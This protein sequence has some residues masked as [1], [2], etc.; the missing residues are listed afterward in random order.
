MKRII[1]GDS[2]TPLIGTIDMILKHWGYR[3]YTS[4]RPEQ[5][6]AALEEVSPDLLIVGADLLTDPESELHR[7]VTRTVGGGDCPLLLLEAPGAAEPAGIAQGSL[8][9]P[10][11]AFALFAYIQELLEKHPRRNLRLTVKLPGMLAKGSHSYL[12]EVLS[13]SS[14]GMFLKT[15]FP[16]KEGEQLQ[17][18][19][20]LMGMKKELKLQGQVLYSVAPTP[21]NNYLQGGGIKF[22]DIDAPSRKVLE[23]FITE[24][25]FGEI[26]QSLGEDSVPRDQVHG[27]N[28]DDPAPSR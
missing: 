22:L 18:V 10:V 19:V 7:L 5:V 3:V 16:L 15:G 28:P 23:Q 2:R 14:A 11:D 20:P 13:L 6:L 8:K 24:R 26:S 27:C 12:G 1:I 17:V 25:F 9:V 21:D 4:S